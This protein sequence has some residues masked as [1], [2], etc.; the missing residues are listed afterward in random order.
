MTEQEILEG[1][2]TAHIYKIICL[3]NNKYYVGSTVNIIRRETQH[4]Y[5]LKKG[6][7]HCK[8]L[9]MAYNKYGKQNFKFEI[10]YT[11]KFII[12]SEIFEIEQKYIDSKDSKFNT[13]MIAG[14][15][16]G[17]NPGPLSKE[18]R[19]KISVAKKG[20]KLSTQHKIK[21][22][23]AAK[24]G[25]SFDKPIIAIT[26]GVATEYRSIC[27]ALRETGV[28]RQ[29]IYDSINNKKRKHRWK[30]ITKTTSIQWKLK[31]ARN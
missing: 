17:S 30:K 25:R 5:S 7:H 18:R 28:P 22:S 14:S 26:N 11:F 13:Y 29:S 23:N 27:E 20:K 1:N 16:L 6:T 8:P 10:I 19:M 21:L 9:Q 3:V 2:K 24:R 4:F 15:P 31:Q 12:K